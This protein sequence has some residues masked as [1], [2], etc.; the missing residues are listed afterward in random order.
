MRT[1]DDADRYQSDDLGNM[2]LL[3]EDGDDEDDGK[4]EA[5]ERHILGERQVENLVKSFE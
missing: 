5:E 2:Q 1:D 3:S 4:N